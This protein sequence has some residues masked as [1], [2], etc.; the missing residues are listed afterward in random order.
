MKNSRPAKCTADA[1]RG[2]CNHRRGAEHVGG[3]IVGP[4]QNGERPNTERDSVSDCTALVSLFPKYRFGRGQRR[5][6]LLVAVHLE[7]A[8]QSHYHEERYT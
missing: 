8:R 2:A 7:R 1:S 4:Q 5:I 3:G 6:P